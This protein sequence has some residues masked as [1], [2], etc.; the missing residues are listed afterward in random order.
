METRPTPTHN[1]TTKWPIRKALSQRFR[2]V[3][4][5]TEL[6][7]PNSLP[8]QR[9]HIQGKL[10][11]C[12]AHDIV[13]YTSRKHEFAR[14]HDFTSNVL[15]HGH[16]HASAGRAVN[17]RI[18]SLL[19]RVVPVR[20]LIRIV[21]AVRVP[22]PKLLYD[23]LRLLRCQAEAVSHVLNRDTLACF[24]DGLLTHHLWKDML[25]V[26]WGMKLGRWFSRHVEFIKNAYSPGAGLY[27]STLQD[28]LT[29]KIISPLHHLA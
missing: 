14:T 12:W 15:A 25:Q 29:A 28:R 7:V 3:H 4:I 21:G 17:T 10:S 19:C 26:R 2:V 13:S 9:F 27:A 16:H 23:S 24:F 22:F 1:A 6:P 18:T 5:S 20:L 8:L 11:Q